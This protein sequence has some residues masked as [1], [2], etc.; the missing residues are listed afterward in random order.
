MA[1]PEALPLAADV[2]VK[3]NQ[4]AKATPYTNAY[5]KFVLK[6]LLAECER[7]QDANVVTGSTYK[8]FLYSTVGDF[9]ETERWIKNAELNGGKDQARLERLTHYV[10]HG[11]ASD[12]LALVDNVFENRLH[13]TVMGIA[14]MIATIGAFN[15]IVNAVNTATAKGEVLQMTNLHALAIKAVDVMQNLG[16]SD[17]DVAAMVDVA[18]EYLRANK[19]LWQGDQPDYTVLDSTHGGPALVIAYRIGVSPQEAAQMGWSLAE[20]LI[21]RGLNRPGVHVDFVG[22][23]IPAQLAA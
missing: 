10:N 6:R 17:A 22:T 13:H 5:N 15:K 18:G 20:A 1:R 21:D 3:L 19:L 23:A 9:A 8:A 16:V 4:F 7:L 11:Y 2:E 14:A 12:A